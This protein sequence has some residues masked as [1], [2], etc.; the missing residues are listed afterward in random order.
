MNQS[1]K[2]S[3]IELKKPN[4]QSLLEIG[5]WKNKEWP[6]KKDKGGHHTKNA[7]SVIHAGTVKATHLGLFHCCVLKA[8]AEHVDIDVFSPG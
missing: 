1:L 6:D 4:L 3:I 2:A 8:K 7:G 5:D